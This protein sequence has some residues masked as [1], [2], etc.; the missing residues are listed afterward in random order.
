VPITSFRPLY[1]I[2]CHVS[3][4]LVLCTDEHIV[5]HKERLVYIATQDRLCRLLDYRRV[6][7]PSIA[8]IRTGR[9]METDDNIMGKKR[10]SNKRRITGFERKREKAWERDTERNEPKT[11]SERKDRVRNR[12]RSRGIRNAER[13]QTKRKRRVARGFRLLHWVRVG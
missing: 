8:G 12:G 5:E 11:W 13:G 3:R 2:T 6:V 7:A 4:E 9:Y 10:K 1:T